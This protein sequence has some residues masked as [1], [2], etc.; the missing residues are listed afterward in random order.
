MCDG[1]EH[2][3]QPVEGT[4]VEQGAGTGLAV[5]PG[6]FRGLELEVVLGAG[7][8]VVELRGRVEQ[9][10]GAAVGDARGQAVLGRGG[11]RR[12]IAAETEPDQRDPLR[13][14]IRPHSQV[15]DHG[16]DDILPVGTERHPHP[17]GSGTRLADEVVA[18]AIALIDE[19][20]DPAALTL[21]GI[22]GLLAASFEELRA[23]ARAALDGQEDP[24]AALIA[25]GRAYVEFAW[26]QPARYRLMFAASGYAP[27]AVATFTLVQE[28]ITNCARAGAS[29]S[30]DPHLDTW[31]LWAA[32]HGVATLDK[33][34]RSDYLRLGPL[35]HP[36]M[37]ETLIRRIARLC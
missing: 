7:Q 11:A 16:R 24:V 19:S 14:D 25:A 36:A 28:A 22:D 18:A 20:N 15:V 37:L 3:V 27:D 13:I 6:A 10:V 34:E 1:L 4:L 5:P 32:L 8:R 33:P 23:A 29:A 26:G 12:E 31:L 17:R 2:L 35:N 30:E 9:V 21:R